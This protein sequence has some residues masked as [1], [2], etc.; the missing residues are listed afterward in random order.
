M[1]ILAIRSIKCSLWLILLFYTEFIKKKSPKSELTRRNVLTTK[2]FR[3]TLLIFFQIALLEARGMVE[4]TPAL[5]SFFEAK[6]IVLIGAS[7]KNNSPGNVVARQ[8]VESFEG[9]VYFVNPRGGR[10]F[11]KKVYKT[12]SKLPNTP[13]LMVVLSP[14]VTVP[15][16]IR[17]A[18]EKNIKNVIISTSG[19]AEIGDVG[20]MYQEEITKIA[21]EYGMRVIGPNC[22]GI[23]A[24]DLSIDTIFLPVSKVRRPKAGQISFFSQSG[25]FGVEFLN[26]MDHLGYGA[27]IAKYI[28]YGNASDI[29]E[30]DVLEYLGQDEKT[31]VILGY[32]E[33]FKEGRRFLDIAKT[34]TPHKPVILIK[35]NRTEIGARASASHTASIASNDK[36]VDDMLRSTG[37]IRVEHWRF[38]LNL[39]KC[40]ATQPMPQG[41][42]VGLLS[43][44]GGTIVMASD[45]IGNWGLEMATLSSESIS[46]LKNEF[47]PFYIVNN[48]VDLTGSSKAKDFEIGLRVFLK[49][50]NVD[51]IVL[52]VLPSAPMLDLVEFLDLFRPLHSEFKAKGKPL[53]AVSLGGEDADFLKSQLEKCDV[54]T[55]SIPENAIRS[56]YQLTFYAEHQMIQES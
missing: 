34:I 44:G 6:S 16:V 31:K 53:L 1:F 27:W 17:E 54:P 41:R 55:Y 21:K 36:V 15:G 18:A 43:N 52:I 22:T 32:L 11:T 20:K 33:G 39:A 10:M 8:L 4:N 14:A 48:P 38:L 26:Q 35:S 47:P 49:D 24:P 30:A 12:V 42:R 40:F 13:D 2:V 29:N 7:K 19:F 28:N 9:E 5:T 50:P 23:Y 46:T 25:A 51:S 56:L 45:A 37:I 3:I